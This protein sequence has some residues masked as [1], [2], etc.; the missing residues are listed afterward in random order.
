MLRQAPGLPHIM[1]PLGWEGPEEAPS[2]VL[3]AQLWPLCPLGAGLMLWW[4]AVGTAGS[5]SYPVL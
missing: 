4:A 3:L 1:W 2:Q 5:G